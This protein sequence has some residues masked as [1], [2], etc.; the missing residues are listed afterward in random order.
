MKRIFML[1]TALS[2]LMSACKTDPARIEYVR[3]QAYDLG[4]KLGD[5]PTTRLAERF[6]ATTP[7]SGSDKYYLYFTTKD[8]LED[9]E[10]RLVLVGK[11]SQKFEKT[12]YSDS[13]D[14][15]F[16]L[17]MAGTLTTTGISLIKYT[18]WHVDK[19]PARFFL[20]ET[21][22]HTSG[23]YLFNGKLITDNIVLILVPR[24]NPLATSTTKQP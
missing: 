2:L 9:F 4:A 10:K 23:Q 5:S 18:L 15:L 1:F 3:K 12:N 21:S 6:E 22:T 17:G 16:D 8:M 19:S 14:P 24:D 11:I 20:Y 13:G 7:V